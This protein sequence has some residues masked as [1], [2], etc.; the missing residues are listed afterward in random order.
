MSPD[1]QQT[2]AYEQGVTL[3][4]ASL[5][6]RS[7]A[8]KAEYLDRAQAEYERFCQQ[9]PDHALRLSADAQLG[10]ILIERARM[11]LQQADRTG[12]EAS[13]REQIVQRAR[14]L[15]DRARQVFEDNQARIRI[16]L[17]QIPKALAEQRDAALIKERER[18]RAE[19]VE[20]QFVAAMIHFEQAQTFTAGSDEGRQALEAAEQAFGVVAEKYRRRVAGLSAVLFQ[21]RCRQALGDIQAALGFYEELLTLP[22]DEPA[23]R[24]LKTKAL[25]GAIDCWLHPDV[26]QTELAIERAEAWLQQRRPDE[27]EDADWLTLQ[28]RLAQAYLQQ[29]NSDTSTR[30]KSR[31]LADARRLAVEVAKQP[32]ATQQQAQEL[33]TQFG[34]T[35]TL[36]TSQVEV[37]TFA[38]ALG[39]GQEVLSQRQVAAGTVSL[40]S[41]RIPQISDAAQ[42]QEAEARLQAAQQQL[43]ESDQK[44]LQ[45]FDRA[46]LLADEET[47]LEQLNLVRFYLCSLH[48]YAGNYCEAAVLASFL[49]RHFPESAE[50][51]RA[52]AVALASLVQLYGDGTSPLARSLTDRIRQTAEDL[53]RRF[54][55][56]PEAEDALGTLVTLAVQAGRVEEAEQFLERLAGRFAEARSGRTGDR[57]GAVEP[58]LRVTHRQRQRSD[59]RSAGLPA[60]ACSGAADARSAAQPARAPDAGRWWQQPSRWRS[61]PCRPGSPRAPWNCWSIRRTVLRCWPHVTI[62]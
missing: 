36:P 1:F 51:R 45:L 4:Q 54:P 10:K 3:V 17:E 62:G 24:L 29:A 16:Q 7:V 14:D 56:Q 46:R 5:T 26:Q 19:Y 11:E 43:R 59:D 18:L 32:G 30:D 8:R 60:P 61:M 47:P 25:S 23:L 9:H 6:Q 31:L 28:L 53:A 12:L 48:Y 44:A 2:L 35:T 13:Q 22:N 40:L 33:L 37:T 49:S 38:E 34:S 21:G 50:G 15:F 41:R 52:G 57:T 20:A 39:A 55:G 27:Q 42:R 58:I